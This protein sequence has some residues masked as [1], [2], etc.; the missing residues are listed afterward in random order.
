MAI[1]RFKRF[2][3][4]NDGKMRELYSELY[5]ILKRKKNAIDSLCRFGVL[6]TKPFCGHTAVRETEVCGLTELSLDF[7]LI[8]RSVVDLV[9]KI[10]ISR[11][12]DR[13]K[14]WFWP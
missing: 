13:F 1:K 8:R 9:C 5:V 11:D 6:C 12:M 7:G 3:G 10:F 14:G 4:H 2:F